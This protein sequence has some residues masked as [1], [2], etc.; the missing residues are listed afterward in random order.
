MLYTE[1]TPRFTDTDAL[2][3][4]NNTKLGDWFE[5]ARRDIFT[6]F[7]PD[8]DIKKWNL[9]IVSTQIDFLAQIYYHDNVMVETGIEKIGNSSFTIAQK[10]MQNNQECARG[11]AVMVHY[12]YQRQQPMPISD[13]IKEKLSVHL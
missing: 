2:G 11:R 12:D 5:S 6:I 8:L 10:V 9:I 13:D 4:I 1:I 3:H 7:V